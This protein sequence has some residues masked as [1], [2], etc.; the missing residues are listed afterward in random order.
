MKETPDRIQPVIASADV[1]ATST[2]KRRTIGFGRSLRG[3]P[4]LLLAGALCLLLTVPALAGYESAVAAYNRGDYQQA[5]TEFEALAAAG[6]A[7]AQPYL[8]RIRAGSSADSQE[9]GSFTS[10][11]MDSVSSLFSQSET[12]S[13]GS[14]ATS[15]N[16]KPSATA[17]PGKGNPSSKPATQEPWSLFGHRSGRVSPS[18]APVTDVV[19]PERRSIWSA[20]FHLPGDATV[21]GLQYV[22]HFLGADN[23]SRELQIL[24]R[25]SD[26]IAL[27]ILAVGWWLVI[28]KVLVGLGVAISRFMKV[29][30]TVVEPKR[31]G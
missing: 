27:S 8:E 11:L 22:A 21:I 29:A 18:P 28:I 13:S 26:K 19:S 6:D 31:Y 25:G 15:G 16:T 10:T 12:S 9:S 20:I 5:E 3:L 17:Q 24:S 7:R 14:G 4:T 30:T 23:L 1:L 2:N